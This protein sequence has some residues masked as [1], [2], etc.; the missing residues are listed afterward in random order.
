MDNGLLLVISGPS[1]AGKG[2]ICKELLSELKNTKF[3]VSATTRQ[4]RAGEVEGVNYYF[5]E[6]D[7]FQHRVSTG[8][9]LEHAV[10]YGNYYGTPKNEVLKQLESG[11]NIIL[12]IDIQGALQVKNSYPQGVFIFVLPPSLIEL[13]NRITQRGTDADDVILKR[14]ECVQEELAHAFLYDYIVLNDKVETA[15]EKIKSIITAEQNRAIRNKNLIER[16]KKE[17]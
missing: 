5:V 15:V 8:D 4:P 17:V 16:F 9:F 2:T 11:N 13:K 12:E 7:I 3:S 14:M 6:K 10:V 1:G